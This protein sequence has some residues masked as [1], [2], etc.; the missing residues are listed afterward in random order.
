[1]SPQQAL[2][3]Y[4]SHNPIQTSAAFRTSNY[5]AFLDGSLVRLLD[6][7]EP[8]GQAKMAHHIF[9]SFVE[10]ERFSCVG[11]KGAV[12]SGGYRFGMYDGFP[13]TQGTHGLARDLAAFVA[14]MPSMNAR[15]KT[16]VAVFNDSSLDEASFERRLWAQL[17]A[18]HDVDRAYFDWD[19]R[20]S[21]DPAD[22]GFAMSA[23]GH[24]FFVVGMHPAASRLTR[25]F[26]FP[27]LV[28]NSHHQFNELR[29]SGHF[30]KIQAHVREREMALQGSLN[31][32]LA[33]HGE[34][35]EAR[36]YSGRAVEEH[37]SCP[38][39]PKS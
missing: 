28:F 7:R 5:S 39:H 11:A 13:S 20:V 24:G 18:L 23:A 3:L 15:Y 4:A 37:W 31:P 19:P 30:A 25:R 34:A 29:A 27:T 8:S 22:A 33:E 21:R 9:R 6:W 12:S 38:F 36:Q 1:M 14:E 17:D 16:F 26:A 2:S 35:S 10:H 32:N